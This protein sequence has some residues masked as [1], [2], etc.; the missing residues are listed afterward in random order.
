[1]LKDLKIGTR[2]GAAIS[3]IVIILLT[4]IVIGS[5]NLGPVAVSCG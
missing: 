2:L 3:L 1:M 4:V 5:A